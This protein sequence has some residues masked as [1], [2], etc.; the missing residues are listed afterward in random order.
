MVAVLRI[1]IFSKQTLYL[2]H[3]LLNTGTQTAPGIGSSVSFCERWLYSESM[4]RI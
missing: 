3:V 2:Q 1:Y 4:G